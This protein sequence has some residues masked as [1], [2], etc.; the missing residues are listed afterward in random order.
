MLRIVLLEKSLKNKIYP[1]GGTYIYIDLPS[2]EALPP[3][4]RTRRCPGPL[5]YYIFC[6]RFSQ[7]I[8]LEICFHSGRKIY[9]RMESQGC[10]GIHSSH[11]DFSIFSNQSRCKSISNLS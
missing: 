11:D 8:V 10:D 4:L 6:S 3:A 9:K 1:C 2:V 7:S 5:T